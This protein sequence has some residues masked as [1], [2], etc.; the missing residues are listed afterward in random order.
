MKEIKAK[1]G[2]YLSDKSK[3]VFFKSIIGVDIKEEDYIEVADSE[4]ESIKKHDKA[5]REMN[6]LEKIDD[7]Y[8]KTGLISECVNIIPMT[9]KEAIERVSLFPEWGKDKGF[10]EGDTVKQGMK[11][12]ITE[13]SVSVLYECI[14][15]HVI[16]ENWKPDRLSSL[17]HEVSYHE[18]TKEDPIPYNEDHNP[19]F[20]GMLL[21]LGK[22]YI[23]DEV[24]YE[25]IRDSQGVKIVQDLAG[26]VD[27]YVKVVK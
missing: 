14:K 19:Q 15:E 24:V 8:Y 25:C 22:F 23:Q 5:I 9:S 11:C 10:M 13:D 18:G 27:N 21:E 3:K 20:Q 6:T 1:D 2:F 4:V 16:Q 7:C 12:K 26:L 17:W